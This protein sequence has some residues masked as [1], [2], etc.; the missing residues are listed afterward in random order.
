MSS[1]TCLR[2]YVSLTEIPVIKRILVKRAGKP[3]AFKR[4]NVL[5]AVFLRYIVIDILEFP[6]V[7]V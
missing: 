7:N 6:G 2:S 1:S 5:A 4:C 3:A